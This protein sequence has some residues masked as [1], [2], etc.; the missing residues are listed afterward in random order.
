[1]SNPQD[2][3]RPEQNEKIKPGQQ[4]TEPGSKSGSRHGQGGRPG[5][6]LDYP[7]SGDSKKKSVPSDDDDEQDAR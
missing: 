7:E 5:E 4:P 3:R 2:S 1:M 6:G